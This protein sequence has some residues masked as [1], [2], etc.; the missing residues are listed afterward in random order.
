AYR[1]ARGSLRS[2]AAGRACVCADEYIHASLPVP[3]QRRGMREGPD[4]CTYRSTSDARLAD[5]MSHG[6]GRRGRRGGACVR[7]ADAIGCTYRP[8][9]MHVCVHCHCAATQKLGDR[10]TLRAEWGAGRLARASGLRSCVYARLADIMSHG[11]GRGV[12]DAIG[13]TF[14]SDMMLCPLR[15][16]DLGV[17][18]TGG[19]TR[20]ALGCGCVS[21]LRMYI[22]AP[23]TPGR[24]RSRADL[25]L[26]M[27]S[28]AGVWWSVSAEDDDVQLAARVDRRERVVAIIH[29][30]PRRV[31]MA[32]ERSTGGARRGVSRAESLVVVP[33]EEV[34]Q[35]WGPIASQYVGQ[36]LYRCYVIW[37]FRRKVVI[38]PALL[39]LSTCV[40][41]IVQ[42]AAGINPLQI[43]L[44]LAAATNLVLTA[45]TVKLESGAIYCIGSISLAIIVSLDKPGIYGI[46]VSIAQQMLNII[47]TFTLVYVGLKNTDYSQSKERIPQVP[48]NHASSRSIAVPPSQPC[49]VL[50]IKPQASE[51]KYGE[52]V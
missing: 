5:V 8:D 15:V 31:L 2:A 13:C 25:S 50:D 6:Q 29:A 18:G 9:M 28:A 1:A 36:P 48:S 4:G 19:E 39:M 26:P 44:S 40:V 24:I 38:A 21:V 49:E 27:R 14:R 34:H 51:E 30:T 41:G 22:L 46:A 52:C 3:V 23:R 42:S 43:T 10:R 11:R 33:A 16:G 45:F 17:S 7:G 20:D 32:L 35:T 37:G 12:W 47:P